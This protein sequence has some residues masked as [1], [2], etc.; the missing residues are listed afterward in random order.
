[1]PKI[2]FGSARPYNNVEEHKVLEPGPAKNFMPNWWKDAT[3]YWIDDSGDPIMASYN[4]DDE[5]EKSLGFKA[6]PALLDVFS[7]GYVLRTPTDIMF[8]Q[9]EGE[10]YVIIDPKY[11]DFCE[12][13]SSMPQFEYPHGYSKK[14]FHWWPNWG[15]QMPEGYSALVTSPLNRN[16]LPF[17]TVNGII[18]SDKYTLPGLMPFFLKEGF[19]GLIPK[20]TP[21]AQVFPIKRESWTSE[22]VYYSN[23]EMYDRHMSI[24]SKFRVKFGGVYKKTTWVKKSYE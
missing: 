8:A 1:M 15:I 7:T 20:G 13:R 18:D 3:K 10:P 12:A 9:Y 22:M 23:D 5:L 4:K 21:F 16:D 6:C 2:K 14:H 11:K 24:V 17:L 19:S